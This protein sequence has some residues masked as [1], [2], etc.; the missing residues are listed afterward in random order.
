MRLRARPL[1]AAVLATTLAMA[2][3]RPR[4]LLPPTAANTV[5]ATL[6]VSC[7]DQTVTFTLTP[8]SASVPLGGTVVWQIDST[9]N[10]DSITIV[11]TKG[12]GNW[13]FESNADFRGRKGRPARAGTMK[14]KV[15]KGRAYKYQIELVCQPTVGPA[16]TVVIDPDVVVN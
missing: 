1:A 14:E 16:H 13:P 11:P 6:N 4:L 2:C 8:W 12:K 3:A 9:S 15:Q 7:D 5:T 10:T